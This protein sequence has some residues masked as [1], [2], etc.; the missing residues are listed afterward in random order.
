MAHFA[1]SDMLRRWGGG[2]RLARRLLIALVGFSSIITA[3]ITT[4]DLYT[5]YR[6]DLQAISESLRFIET[7]AVPSLSRSVWQVDGELTQSQ[8]DGLLRLRDIEYAGIEVQG[9]TRWAAGTVTSSRQ[10]VVTLPLAQT[11]GGATV[12][13]GTL[14]VVAGIDH[15]IQRVWDRALIDLLSNGIKTLLVAGFVM[16]V[17]HRLVTQHLMRVAD[18]VKQIEIHPGGLAAPP[19]TLNLRRPASKPG[20]ADILDT[21]KDAINGLLRSLYRAQVDLHASHE[22]LSESELRFRLAMEAAGAGLW[23]CDFA[24][25]RL[26]GNEQSARIL[27]LSAKELAVAPR[28]WRRLLHPDDA[29]GTMETIRQHLAGATSDL[30]IEARMRHARAGWRWM[31]VRGGVVE[32]GAANEPL[33]AVGALVDIDSRRLAEEALRDANRYLESRVRERTAAL[34]EARDEA[35]RANQAKSDFLSR[36]SHELRTPLNG[37][38]GFAQ[39]LQAETALNERQARAVNI[40][41]QSGQHLLTLINDI[42]D[43]ARM[44]AASLDLYPEPVQLGPYLGVIG[45][46][47]RVSAEAKG[48]RFSLSVQQDLPSVVCVD[49]KRLRQVLLNLLSNAV[50]FTDTGEVVL[51]VRRVPAGATVLRF[52][53]QDCGIGMNAEQLARLFRPFEQVSDAKR[54][55]G[56]TGLGLAISREL[57]R[58]MGSDLHVESRLGEGSLFWFD[59]PLPAAEET[60]VSGRLHTLPPQATQG[61]R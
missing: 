41:Q 58:A 47:V 9:R 12:G 46:M 42:L 16:V 30:R 4:V 43:L 26:Y 36:M 20:Q 54:R 10:Q 3:V 11:E 1:R 56:G 18:F 60:A 35:E 51:R 31:S 15:A 32:R 25:R 44:G 19:E 61:E 40:I 55:Q 2:N 52:E 48:L 53:V 7:S 37:I 57:A 39:I 28:F 5:G 27:G 49:P 29:A 34:Q 22:R 45:E 21:V 6:R 33:R 50:K 8:L 13:I 59:L 14:R 38:L 17:F 23:D 24:A